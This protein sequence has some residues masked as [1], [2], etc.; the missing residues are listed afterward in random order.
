VG[1][2]ADRPPK[3]DISQRRKGAI[4]VADLT[5][6]IDSEELSKDLVVAEASENPCVSM[7]NDARENGYPQEPGAL[8]WMNSARLQVDVED[9]AITCLI[10]VGD[11]RGA[12][13]FTVRRLSDGRLAIHVP[14]PG[15]GMPHVEIEAAPWE[16]T[17]FT[18]TNFADEQ[19]D[20]S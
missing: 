3:V 18:R 6:S 9:D 14:Y 4:M 16:G 20:E 13:A 19:E 7:R 17:Y 1:A 8:S 11:P 2:G 12:W 5:L 15:E 10:S